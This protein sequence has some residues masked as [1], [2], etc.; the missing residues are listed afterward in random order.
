MRPIRL[1]GLSQAQLA[2]LDHL[3]RTAREGRMRIRALMV[4][5]AAERGMLAAQIAAVVREH[6]HTVRR[7]LVRYRAEGVAGLSDAPR[8]G[9]P[10]KATPAYR[11]RLLAVVRRRPRS[12]G[13]PFSLWTGPR[14]VDY[15]AEQT[16][17]RLSRE[18]VYRLARRRRAPQSPAAHDHEP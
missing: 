8:P 15:L 10:P 2:E 7:W 17:L 1:T 3:Y 16:G 12:M 9:A 14:L 4:L 6:E 13:L 18:S 11:E 5:L